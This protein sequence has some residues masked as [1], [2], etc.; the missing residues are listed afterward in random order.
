M[1]IRSAE[2][3]APATFGRWRTIASR[4]PSTVNRSIRHTLRPASRLFISPVM[5]AMCASGA[6]TTVTPE[7]SFGAASGSRPPSYEA[8]PASAFSKLRRGSGMR[9]GLPVVPLDSIS[10]AMPG[11]A[12]RAGSLATASLSTDASPPRIAT[13]AEPAARA[14]SASPGRLQSSARAI[15]MG[16]AASTMSAASFASGETAFRL[17]RHRPLRN[18]A[19]STGTRSA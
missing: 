6:V 3:G 1:I 2:G 19:S 13:A 12:R 15:K 4:N 10:I 16:A 7:R 17:A 5:P 11:A 18:S 9:L 8:A 14:A